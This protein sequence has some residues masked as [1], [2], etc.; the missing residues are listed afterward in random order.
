LISFVIGLMTC[1]TSGDGGIT[2]A[3]VVADIISSFLVVQR[4]LPGWNASDTVRTRR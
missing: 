4:E 3:V 1:R 2:R